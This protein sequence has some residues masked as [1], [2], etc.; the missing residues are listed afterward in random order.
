MDKI[1]YKMFSRLAELCLGMVNFYFFFILSKVL[2]IN[3][4]RVLSA[5]L[6]GKWKHQ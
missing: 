2:K 1:L 3:F 6:D 4:G 5:A